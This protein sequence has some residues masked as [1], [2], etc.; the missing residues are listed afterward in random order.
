M[1]AMLMSVLLMMSSAANATER[2]VSDVQGSLECSA[3]FYR[4]GA[5]GDDRADSEAK[6]S[7]LVVSRAGMLKESEVLISHF[8]GR[9][10]EN[11][12]TDAIKIKYRLYSLGG[13]LNG[14]YTLSLV[15]SAGNEKPMMR[16]TQNL[17]M[18]SNRFVTPTLLNQPDHRMTWMKSA[19][20]SC[21]VKL[22]GEGERPR[23]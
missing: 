12:E 14:I 11:I 16:I 18:G 13:E 2:N 4:K 17:A 6:S 5:D 10:G 20:L 8:N 15:D 7:K 23:N 3:T 21:D 19:I 1:K 22:N 9:P